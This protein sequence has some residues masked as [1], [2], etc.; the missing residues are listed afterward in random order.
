M[1]EIGKTVVLSEAWRRGTK[2]DDGGDAGGRRLALSPKLLRDVLAAK[3]RELIFLIRLRRYVESSRSNG[4]EYWHTLATVR[5]DKNMKFHLYLGVIN[6][7]HA[8]RHT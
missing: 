8:P 4:S 6:Q 3:N 5:L 7:L 1:D 2:H